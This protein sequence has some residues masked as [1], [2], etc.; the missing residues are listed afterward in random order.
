MVLAFP[1]VVRTAQS[2]PR[3]HTILRHPGVGVA[4]AYLVGVALRVKYTIDIHPPEAFVSSDMSLYVSLA[5]RLLAAGGPEGPWDVTHP[6][7]F[8]AFLAFLLSGGG[9]LARAA[10]VQLVVSCLVPGAVG[11]LGAAAFGRRAG[12]LAVVF[13]S[14]YFP[15]I[16]YGAL[17]LS[18]VHF[19]LWL[20]LAFAGFL[21][22]I[23]T[24]RRAV[25]LALAAG[26]GLALSLAIAMKNVGLLAA[27]AFFATEGVALVLARPTAGAHPPSSSWGTRLRPWAL[28]AAVAAAGAAPLL[29]AQTKICTRANGGHFCFAGNK[30]AADFLLGHYG[31]IEG[32][33]WQP[34]DGHPFGFGSPG[35]VLRHYEG[36]PK[37]AWVIA[38]NAANA[39]EAWRWIGAHPYDAVVLSFDHIFDTFFGSAMWP[40]FGDPS[41]REAHLFQYVFIALLFVPTL[42]GTARV[43]RGGARAFLTS[44]LALVVS[45]I[46]ALAITVAIATGEVRY[47]V[48]FDVFFIVIACAY[49]TRELEPITAQPR[50]ST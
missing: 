13:A 46:G 35:A 22:A 7:G 21:G 18:E 25:S 48:P 14:L 43:A 23:G 31:R 40:S 41:W 3:V 2:L 49:A 19:T 27:L 20:A 39:A 6:L 42:L 10:H 28:R 50:S 17:F 29:V 4:L 34:Y 26:G 15:F 16:A 9:S 33:D 8:P 1:I 5:R 37:V 11:L 12:L 32:L 44:R 38:D 47:R 30:P 24:R 45:P 36:H